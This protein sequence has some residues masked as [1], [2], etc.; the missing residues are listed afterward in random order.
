[1]G[2]QYS[3]RN[4]M[5]VLALL[6]LSNITP[7]VP[8]ENATHQ[9]E[10]PT[11]SLQLDNG[12]KW[13]TDQ[14]LRQ[15]M[16]EIRDAVAAQHTAIHNSTATAAQYQALAVKVDDRIA[17]MVANCKLKPEADTNLHIILADM[18][19]GSDLMKGAD[20]AKQRSGA[21]KVMA[22]LQAYPKYFD[23]PGWRAL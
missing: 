3:W 19:A 5:L 1:M 16:T 13:Q 14:P 20:A 10:A 22:A 12:K 18:I 4:P 11:H 21:L 8:A 7:A 23:H 6:A 2:T 17:Y 15:A 9:H